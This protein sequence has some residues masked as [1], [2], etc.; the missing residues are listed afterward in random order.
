MAKIRL[1]DLDVTCKEPG[2]TD[3]HHD[4]GHEASHDA[5]N[6]HSKMPYRE[7]W[8]EFEMKQEQQGC[9]SKKIVE[10]VISAKKPHRPT[11]KPPVKIRLGEG[12]SI[13]RTAIQMPQSKSALLKSL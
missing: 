2:H 13:S 10:R 6:P 8:A 11:K 4:R 9:L 3:E 1:N 7:R 5:C 12:S